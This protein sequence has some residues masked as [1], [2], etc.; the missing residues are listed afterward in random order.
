VF[1]D[2]APPEHLADAEGDVGLAAERP[3]RAGGRGGDLGQF[4]FGRLQ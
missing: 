4:A 2:L 3:L 1:A